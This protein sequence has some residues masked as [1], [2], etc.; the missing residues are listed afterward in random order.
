LTTTT[1][2]PTVRR[3]IIASAAH[4]SELAPEV[5]F[6]R[7]FRDQSVESTFAGSAFM[8]AF[9]AFYYSFSPAVAS[10]MIQSPIL[11]EA[12]KLLLYPLV[13]VLRSASTVF[14]ALALAPE[15][16]VTISGLVASTLTGVMY[17]APLA[18]IAN[19]WSRRSRRRH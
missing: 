16:A 15:L 3:C 10:T 8:K 1:V 11:Q 13:A 19:L 2:T 18:T 4:G 12:V 6:L 5:Q 7:M 9:N 17:L 14:N